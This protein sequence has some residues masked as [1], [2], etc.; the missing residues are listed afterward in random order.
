MVALIEEA[1]TH[2]T[3]SCLGRYRRSGSGRLLDLSRSFLL[4]VTY[5]HILVRLDVRNRCP[6]ARIAGGMAKS[7][8]TCNCHQMK[9]VSTPRLKAEHRPGCEGCGDRFGCEVD[10][11]ILGAVYCLVKIPH[12]V[13]GEN[14]YLIDAASLFNAVQRATGDQRRAVRASARRYHRDRHPGWQAVDL[15]GLRGAQRDEKRK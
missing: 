15:L 7:K 6:V 12:P 10:F 14:E 13:G 11:D 4:A 9:A 8:T 5:W 1:S 2:S 3:L